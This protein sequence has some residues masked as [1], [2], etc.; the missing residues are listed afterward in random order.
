ML[1]QPRHLLV[2]ACAAVCFGFPAA[3]AVD[4]GAVLIGQTRTLRATARV[5]DHDGAGTI[6][7]QDFKEAI[8]FG[9]FEDIAVASVDLPRPA[10]AASDF[11]DGRPNVAGGFAR[12]TMSSALSPTLF[13]ASGEVGFVSEDSLFGS[14][15]CEADMFFKVTFRIDEPHHVELIDPGPG[16]V[17]LLKKGEGPVA[18]NFF[19]GV[20]DP[21]IYTLKHALH[22]EGVSMVDNKQYQLS[23][24]L[25]SIN[26][27][28]LPPA[29]MSG[30]A[31]MILAGA[32]Y[33]I[34]RG[35]RNR[36]VEN[37]SAG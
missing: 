26:A 16:E 29:A 20:L 3:E 11:V 23:L 32:G 34:V 17:E 15:L 28:P 19:D 18:T 14:Q 25:D 4:A 12:A 6:T 2:T 7:K 24:S 21:G 30:L 13:K 35:G 22:V 8:D 27:I 1:I 37:K 10:G 33:M 9:A 36:S 31:S 5:E